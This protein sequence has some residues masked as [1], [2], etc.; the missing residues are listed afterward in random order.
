M[1]VPGPCHLF[2]GLP[3]WAVAELGYNVRELRLPAEQHQLRTLPPAASDS[4]ANNKSDFRK[5][6][7]KLENKENQQASGIFVRVFAGFVAAYLGTAKFG[8]D[9][10]NQPEYVPWMDDEYSTSMPAGE[11]YDG[12][13]ALVHAD[14]NLWAEPIYRWISTRVK[15]LPAGIGNPGVDLAGNVGTEIIREVQS[16]PLWIQFPYG[17]KTAFA[18]RGMPQGRRYW[19]ARV[20]RDNFKDPGHADALIQLSFVCKRYH[21]L[22]TGIQVLYDYNMS[23]VL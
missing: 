13:S 5:G 9:I 1:F 22:L 8:V 16:F 20:A 15:M 4:A 18:L 6:G 3:A 12:E 14:I 19:V 7:G 2:V 11:L 21:D 17:N 23:S 10:T